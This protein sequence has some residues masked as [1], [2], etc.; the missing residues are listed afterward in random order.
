LKGNVIADP[1]EWV[2]DRIHYVQPRGVALEKTD[3][4]L[5]ADAE[6]FVAKLRKNR[7]VGILTSSADPS[8]KPFT[9]AQIAK[10]PYKASRDIGVP[11]GGSIAKGSTVVDVFWWVRHHQNPLKYV[12]G[13]AGWPQTIDASRLIPV[14][15]QWNGAPSR[16]ARTLSIKCDEILTKNAEDLDSEPNLSDNDVVGYELE[17]QDSDDSE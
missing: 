17:E 2:E 16:G 7:Y 10:S 11:S 5:V 12:K 14:K 13:N 6:N 15:V 4:K 1:G 9:I 8:G 3:R